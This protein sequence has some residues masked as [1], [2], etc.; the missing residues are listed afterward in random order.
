MSVESQKDMGCSSLSVRK[1][2]SGKNLGELHELVYKQP[3]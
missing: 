2:I 3:E 1:E